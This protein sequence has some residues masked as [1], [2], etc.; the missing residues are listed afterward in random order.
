MIVTDSVLAP[1]AAV[2]T[3]LGLSAPV[4][5][6]AHY[7]E[8]LAFVEECFE[9]FGAQDNHPIFA[10]VD[11]VAQRIQEYEDRLHP[12]PDAS[13]PATRLAFLM[14]QH[15]LRQSDLPEVGAQSVVSDV[16]SGK[17]KLNLRQTQALARR[18]GVPVDA[19]I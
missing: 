11:I 10:L 12:W 1:W 8:L 17:R 14:D 19:L 15:G 2:N 6:E 16:L 18:F 3:A 9:R 7:T 5:D 13:T 4:R